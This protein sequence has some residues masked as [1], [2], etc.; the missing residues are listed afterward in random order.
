MPSMR[1]W[2][3][4]IE[5]FEHFINANEIKDEKQVS[6]LLSLMCMQMYRLLHSLITP[7]QP[8]DMAFQ[9]IV[10][11]LQAHF[12][13]K[14]LNTVERFRF[15]KRNQEEGETVAQYALKR[16]KIL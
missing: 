9:R 4:F 2:D 16:L 3:T 15:Y 1:Q 5:S 6:V 7:E 12:S 13:P 10:Y 8:G 11:E 14:P